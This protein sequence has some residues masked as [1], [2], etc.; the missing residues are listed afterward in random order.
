MLSSLKNKSLKK[1]LSS[2]SLKVRGFA[3]VE[4]LSFMILKLIS[5]DKHIQDYTLFEVLKCLYTKY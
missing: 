1:I 3:K 5:Q 4:Y 2:L